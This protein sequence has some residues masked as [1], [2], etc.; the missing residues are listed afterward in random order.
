MSEMVEWGTRFL[1][2]F[3]NY[4]M[5]THVLLDFRGTVRDNILAQGISIFEKPKAK[6][7]V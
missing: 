3:Q 5:K 1:K 6:A 7:E 4:H 2:V